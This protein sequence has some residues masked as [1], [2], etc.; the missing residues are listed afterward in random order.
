MRGDIAHLRS[1]RLWLR[2]LRPEDAPALVAGVGNYDVSRWLAVVPFPYGPEDARNFLASRM[3][4]PRIAWAVCEGPDSPAC[5]VISIREELGYWFARHVW[6]KGYGVEAGDAVIDAAFCDPTRRA[7]RASHMLANTRSARVLDKLGFR[8]TGEGR[9]R[10]RALGQDAPVR[11][12]EM[13]RA[14]WVARRRYRLRTARLAL[15]EL[16]DGDL[17]AL[18]RIGGHP[19]VARQLLSVVSPW[20][21]DA[22]RRWLA[23]GRYRGRPGFRAGICRRGRLIGTLYMGAAPGGGPATCAWFLDPAHWGQGYVA[24]AAHAF[25]A[26]TMDRFG[27]ATLWADHFADN[28]ASGRVMEKLGFVRT[29]TG[30]GTSAARLEPAPIVVYRLDRANLKGRP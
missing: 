1:A 6:G 11:L 16:R 3:A 18:R 2:P 9:R 27:I 30:T 14:D 17:P 13:T 19:E 15:R 21:E 10:F 23:H 22:A 24:E 25:L 7:I 20:P 4:E 28:P 12:M 5:G 29:G 26:D 8:A